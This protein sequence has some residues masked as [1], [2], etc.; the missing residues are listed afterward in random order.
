MQSETHVVVYK[1]F[2]NNFV[3]WVFRVVINTSDFE[4]ILNL[5]RV[6]FVNNFCENAEYQSSKSREVLNQA[7]QKV[8]YKFWSFFPA[9]VNTLCFLTI[10]IQTFWTINN[11]YLTI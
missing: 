11:F 2:Q 8:I 3:V 10:L 7:I 1:Q 6:E 5:G 4:V 9:A